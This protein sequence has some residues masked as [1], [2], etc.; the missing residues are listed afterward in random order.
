MNS[1]A[2]WISEQLNKRDFVTSIE[3]DGNRLSIVR[4]SRPT[5]S[6]GVLSVRDVTAA[7]VLPLVEGVQ[8]V[9]FVLNKPKTGRFMGDALELLELKNVG[10]GGLGDA[11][12]ALRDFDRLGDYQERELTFVMRGLRQHG[13]VTSLTLLDDHRI[14]VVRQGLPDRVVFVGSMYQPT[15][16]T[17]RDAIDRYGDFDLFA[18]TNP[19][20]DPT[21]EAIEVAADA[22][23]QMLKWRET[24]AALYR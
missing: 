12:R 5:A 18:A 6:V 13:R 21:A 15:A 2:Q 9:D 22:G 14:A 8:S 19:N 10:W 23:I 17:V 16:E 1:S 3:V 4:D 20:S 24:L 11:I 7:D